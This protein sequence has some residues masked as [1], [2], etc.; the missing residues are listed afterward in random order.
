MTE[1]KPGRPQSLGREA[2]LADAEAVLA[3]VRACRSTLQRD[4]PRTGPARLVREAIWFIWEQPR[5]PR[6]LVASKYPTSYPW[7]ARA[8]AIYEQR[9][10]RRPRGGWGL[11]I[12]H[13]YPR[14]LLVEDL[15]NGDNDSSAVVELLTR[16]VTAAETSD[17]WASYDADPWLRYRSAPLELS[18]FTVLR[19]AHAAEMN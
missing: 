16:R 4:R 12:D 6:P 14:E 9:G 10:G 7:S 1:P 5:L 15:L 2:D 3:V 8:Q 19:H 13:L 18:T 11:V 17:A